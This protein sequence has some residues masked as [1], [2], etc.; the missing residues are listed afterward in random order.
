M[1]KDVRYLWFSLR[2]WR[3][4]YAEEFFGELGIWAEKRMEELG[5]S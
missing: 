4:G 3:G 1:G 5:V 2:D